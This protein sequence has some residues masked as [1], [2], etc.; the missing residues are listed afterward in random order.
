LNCKQKKSTDGWKFENCRVWKFVTAYFNLSDTARSSFLVDKWA[1]FLNIRGIITYN[2]CWIRNWEHLY[3]TNDQLQIEKLIRPDGRKS[4]YLLQI[5][6]CINNNVSNYSSFISYFSL[7]L[8]L[9]MMM[10]NLVE[11]LACLWIYNFYWMDSGWSWW[12]CGE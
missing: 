5:N 6:W 4:A 8:M 9:I 3:I 7:I 2:W 12:Q 11:L 10:N 1:V